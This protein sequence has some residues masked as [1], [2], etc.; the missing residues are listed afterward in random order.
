MKV[1][2]IGAT[3]KAGK[4]ILKESFARNHDVT[5]I[6]RNAEKLEEG[7]IGVINKDIFHLTKDDV[8]AF[9]VI[10]NAFGA[11][12]GSE[13]L[14]VEGGRHLIS[15]FDGMKT[16]LI[17]VGG[18]GSLFVD[19]DKK[20]RVAETPEFPDF[21]RPTAMNQLQNLLDLEDS[22]IKWTFL[23][24]SAEFDP[25]GVRTG[26]YI[27]GLDH[28]LVNKSGQSYVSYADYAIAIVDE[29]EKGKHINKRFTV[30]S[31]KGQN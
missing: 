8:A 19:P 2:I 11:P 16:R 6:I 31:E 10:V 27:E 20:I 4:A 29:I 9:D 23:S 15:I 24:P 3:G 13:H 26:S 28:L 17:V 14:H 25:E 30:A 1:G 18:A 22:G 5:A 7:S 12:F 21:V